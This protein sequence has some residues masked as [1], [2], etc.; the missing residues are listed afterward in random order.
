MLNPNFSSGCTIS[1]LR[2]AAIIPSDNRSMADLGV[3]AGAKNPVHDAALAPLIPC[4][5]N[6]GRSGNC[7]LRFGLP[8]ARP[9][10]CPSLICAITLGK[11]EL[12]RSIWP[13]MRSCTK[14]GAPR[15]GTCV[16]L[17]PVRAIN[18]SMDKCDPDPMPVEPY[19]R[20]W[21]LASASKSCMDC[22]GRSLRTTK[23]CSNAPTPASGA[24]SL[25]AS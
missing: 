3:A 11:V 9:R 17:M 21:L 19:L 24:K 7:G 20:V 18:N 22:T 14:G 16:I 1:G 4:S 8:K 5:S 13:P 2:R 10:N 23:T 6:V 12:A 25:T 15:Y